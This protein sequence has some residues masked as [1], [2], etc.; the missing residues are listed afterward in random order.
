MP[1]KRYVIGIVVPEEDCVL[2]PI[3]NG[4]YDV[5]LDALRRAKSISDQPFTWGTVY[6]IYDRKSDLVETIC[7]NGQVW[8][9]GSEDYRLIEKEDNDE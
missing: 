8:V 2:D 6:A 5:Q 4:E 1:E 7:I 9:G 3:E